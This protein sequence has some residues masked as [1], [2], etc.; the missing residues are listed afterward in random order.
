MKILTWANTMKSPLC[1]FTFRVVL[2]S[3][4]SKF[5]ADKIVWNVTKSSETFKNFRVYSPNSGECIS[6]LG[7][8]FVAAARHNEKYNQIT[9]ITRKSSH[10]NLDL[11]GFIDA[12]IGFPLINVKIN[13]EVACWY[14]IIVSKKRLNLFGCVDSSYRPADKANK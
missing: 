9:C 2:I 7:H 5:S 11:R 8:V 1:L 13:G 10:R 3:T 6:R 12:K 4:K 14:A